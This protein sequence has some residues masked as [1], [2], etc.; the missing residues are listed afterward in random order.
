MDRALAGDL[1]GRKCGECKYA[2]LPE[3]QRESVCRERCGDVPDGDAK[4]IFFDLMSMHLRM[5]GGER[6][7]RDYPYHLACGYLRQQLIARITEKTI[8]DTLAK[9]GIIKHGT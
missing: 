8:I 6:I 3:A 1:S 9:T 7:S 2:L 4:E 5:L